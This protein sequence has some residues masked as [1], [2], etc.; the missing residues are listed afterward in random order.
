MTLPQSKTESSETT[1]SSFEFYIIGFIVLNKELVVF[2][3]L[4]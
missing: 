2:N 3:Y 1:T 4:C